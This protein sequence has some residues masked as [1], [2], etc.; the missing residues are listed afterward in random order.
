MPS[1]MIRYRC[2]VSDSSEGSQLTWSGAS[3]RPSAEAILYAMSEYALKP[4]S[5]NHICE[6][7]SKSTLEAPSAP[8]GGGGIVAGKT[9]SGGGAIDGRDAFVSDPNANADPPKDEEHANKAT[10]RTRRLPTTVPICPQDTSLNRVRQLTQAAF[11][12]TNGRK[13]TTGFHPTPTLC[14]TR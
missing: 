13:L 9:Q 4:P 5:P 3:L 12:L 6:S 7:F 8:G 11:P 2:N 1:R 14:C 10:K